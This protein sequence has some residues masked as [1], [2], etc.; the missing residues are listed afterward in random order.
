MALL[1]E[2]KTQIFITENLQLKKITIYD[3]GK[4]ARNRKS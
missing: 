2:E 3:F 4:G 1:D